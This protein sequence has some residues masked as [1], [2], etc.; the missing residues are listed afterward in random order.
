MTLSQCRCPLSV[1]GWV[2]WENFGNFPANPEDLAK[3][4]AAELMCGEE[5]DLVGGRQ[6]G[7][8]GAYEVKV[9][10]RYGARAWAKP[11]TAAGANARAAAHE[12]LCRTSHM[13]SSFRSRQ[14]C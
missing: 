11:S 4:C 3:H 8:S 7:G 1:S 9:K 5:F 2:R 13:P 12:R 10:G 6:D 14:P